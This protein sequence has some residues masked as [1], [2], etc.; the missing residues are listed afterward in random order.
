MFAASICGQA[1]FSQVFEIL[2]EALQCSCALV[3]CNSRVPVFLFVIFEATANIELGLGQLVGRGSSAGLYSVF[4]GAVS[5]SC[6]PCKR[7]ARDELLKDE[8]TGE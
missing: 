6:G 3:C 2:T 8:T 1:D 5:C 7:P 4:E